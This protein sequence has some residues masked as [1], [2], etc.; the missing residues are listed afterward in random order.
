MAAEEA[1]KLKSQVKGYLGQLSRNLD[2][3]KG[4]IE[5][6]KATRSDHDIKQMAEYKKRAEGTTVR[7]IYPRGSALGRVSISTKLILSA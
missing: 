6:A 4:S 3:L 5:L 7:T 1:K 2:Q